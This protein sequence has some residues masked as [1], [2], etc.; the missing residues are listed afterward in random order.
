MT[1]EIQ[2]PETSTT[3][4]TAPQQSWPEMLAIALVITLASNAVPNWAISL[5]T[6]RLLPKP[7]TPQQMQTLLDSLALAFGLLLVLPTPRR[8]GL[9]LG[10]I[11]RHLWKIAL[12]VIVPII[13][14]AIV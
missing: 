2:E 5:G 8:S 7:H 12:V 10:K 4:P 3:P 13:L 14:T 1:L 6:W 9:I 11:D